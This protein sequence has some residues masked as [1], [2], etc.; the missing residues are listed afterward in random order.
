MIR[1]LL[2]A[3]VAAL[4]LLT[5]SLAHARY[6]DH[7]IG[8]WEK[9]GEKSVR[10]MG[11]R[12]SLH[13]NKGPYTK[14]RFSVH[15]RAVNF[16]RVFVEFGNGERVEIEVRDRIH[17]GGQSRVIDLPG[18]ARNIKKIIFW[19]KTAPGNL[20]RAKVTVWARR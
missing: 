14:L 12:D 10:L 9:L 6:N 11:E 19:Y 5:G 16:Q 18:R 3:F 4:V 8:R 20:E 2:A 17:A 1:N 15:D 13:V 7:S